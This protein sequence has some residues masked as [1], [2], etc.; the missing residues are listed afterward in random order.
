MANVSLKGDPLGGGGRKEKQATPTPGSQG[1]NPPGEKGLNTPV[2]SLSLSLQIE[3]WDFPTPQTPRGLHGLP[4]AP[5]ATPS[6]FASCSPVTGRAGSPLGGG[7][8][9]KPTPHF[10]LLLPMEE[11]VL[12]PH[13]W[14][15]C[16]PPPRR[17]LA[18]TLTRTPGSAFLAAAQP[19]SSPF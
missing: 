17:P 13:L 12:G 14:L 15:L 6:S 11:I 18:P 8:E 10:H 19:P 1:T 4:P 7:A 2:F 5:F 3:T 16:S 9:E